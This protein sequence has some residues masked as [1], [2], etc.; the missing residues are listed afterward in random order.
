[1]IVQFHN[2]F[3]CCL[4]LGG[5]AGWTIHVQL[6]CLILLQIASLL[7]YAISTKKYVENYT[8]EHHTEGRIEQFTNGVVILRETCASNTAELTTRGGI[9]PRGYTCKV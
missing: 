8:I 6:A 9:S 4:Y 1:M 5:T 2:F 3:Q 7:N